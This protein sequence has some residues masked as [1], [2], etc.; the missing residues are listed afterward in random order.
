[1][2]RR[3]LKTDLFLATI[4]RGC[5]KIGFDQLKIR[6]GRSSEY[7]GRTAVRFVGLTVLLYDLTKI[8][9]DVSHNLIVF[10]YRPI[11]LYWKMNVAQGVISRSGLAVC[12]F[13]LAISWVHC[14]RDRIETARNSARDV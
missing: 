13:R 6:T 12:C 1:M 9:C 4:F 11:R 5:R 10:L 8:S 2:G 14:R 3:D 7:F